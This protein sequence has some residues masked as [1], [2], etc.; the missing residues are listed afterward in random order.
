[1]GSKHNIHQE[2]RNIPERQFFQGEGGKAADTG[3]LKLTVLTFAP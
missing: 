1:M 2:S 3:Y